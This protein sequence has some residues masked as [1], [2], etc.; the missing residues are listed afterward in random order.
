MSS[1]S[2]G[3]LVDPPAESYGTIDYSTWYPDVFDIGSVPIDLSHLNENPAGKH[4]FIKAVGDK[5]MAEDGTPMRFFGTNVTSY[6]L[7]GEETAIDNQARRIAQLGYNLVRLHH[8]DSMSWVDPSVINRSRN[9]SRELNPAAMKKIDHWIES[10]KKQGIYV[11]LDLHVGRVFKEGDAETPQDRERFNEFFG[12]G[13]K[14]GQGKAFCYYDD[15]LKLLMRE[16]SGKYLNWENSL[17][18]IKYKDDPA[19]M[20]ILITNENDLT[21]HGGNALLA[22]KKKAALQRHIPTGSQKIRWGSRSKGL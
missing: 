11:W 14:E 15:R 12:E 9:D 13:K 4:G 17:S 18:K 5:L 8:H 10:L 7:F 6:A 2:G 16:F 20:G 21:H 1:Q 3:T 19:I 22:D